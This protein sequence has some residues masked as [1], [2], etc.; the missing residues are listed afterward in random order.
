MK[1]TEAAR[2]L[3]R[4]AL[5]RA[6]RAVARTDPD[7]SFEGFALSEEERAILRRQDEE[8]LGLLAEILRARAPAEVERAP[9]PPEMPHPL[10][11]TGRALPPVELILQVVPVISRDEAGAIRLSHLAS[12]YAAPPAGSPLPPPPS[13][14]P[15]GA[16]PPVLFRIV[17]APHAATLPDGG[18]L[19]T[20]AGNLVSIEAE[21]RAAGAAAARPSSPWGHRV[22]SEGARRAARAVREAAPADRYARLLDLVAALTGEGESR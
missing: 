21:T 1:P 15:E 3:E 5:D 13:G 18:T 9:E 8:M 16:R 2:Y 10:P 20:Y 11:V 6:F 17:V 14:A 12:L 22:D 7:A 19:V 4:A